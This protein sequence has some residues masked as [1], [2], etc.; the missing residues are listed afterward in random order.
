MDDPIVSY[1]R[2]FF[3]IYLNLHLYLHDYTTKEEARRNRERAGLISYTYPTRKVNLPNK[4]VSKLSD[5]AYRER[6]TEIGGQL[7]E[8]INGDDHLS[9]NTIANCQCQGQWSVPDLAS[10]SG[11]RLT[12]VMYRVGLLL[13]RLRLQPD[14]GS[15]DR[16]W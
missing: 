14:N 8:A 3:S 1:L 7:S 13:R 4:V 6:M 10:S 2:W 11:T 12:Q 16:E 15:R 5:T 9:S